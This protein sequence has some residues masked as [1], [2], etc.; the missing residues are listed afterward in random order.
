MALTNQQ[1]IDDYKTLHNITEDIHTYAHWKALGR[2]VRKGEH[3]CAKILI[4]KAVPRKRIDTDADEAAEAEGRP[5]MI[6]KVA[7]FFAE[8]QTD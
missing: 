4:W 7:Y 5:R 3:A 2:Q 8:S 6:R 1:I